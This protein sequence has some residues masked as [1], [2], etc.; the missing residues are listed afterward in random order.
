ML[1]HF[2]TVPHVVVIPT[3]KLI[4][5]LLHKSLNHNVSICLGTM[6]HKL[7]TAALYPLRGLWC[8][9]SSL[10][11]LW[12]DNVWCEGESLCFFSCSLVVSVVS[13]LWREAVER[14]VLS[15]LWILDLCGNITQQSLPGACFCC[16]ICYRTILPFSSQGKENTVYLAHPK[17]PYGGAVLSVLGSVW[18]QVPL[19]KTLQP[20][21]YLLG[22]LFFSFLQS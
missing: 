16:W 6:T 14:C 10:S 18:G 22:C 19:S 7:R 12:L 13:S 17:P 5:L 3:I 1:L 11:G 9:V 15:A 4:F 21:T 2:N 8:W 20:F